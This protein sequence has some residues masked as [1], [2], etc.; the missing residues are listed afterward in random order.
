MRIFRNKWLAPVAFLLF[1]VPS[2]CH[3]NSPDD[4][5]IPRLTVNPTVSAPSSR[6]A[7]PSITPPVLPTSPSCD[8]L[9]IEQVREALG[10]GE[11]QKPFGNLF[12]STNG[13]AGVLLDIDMCSWQQYAGTDPGRVVQVEVH[14]AKSVADA[15][16]EYESAISQLIEHT[17]PNFRPLPVLNLGARAARLPEWLVVQKDRVMLAVSVSRT[18]NGAAPDPSILEELA[19][20][21]ATRLGW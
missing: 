14:T 6:A 4:S 17:A 7:N 11:V 21:V 12:P 9:T 1:L 13:F 20:D 19:R 5:E 2:G 3:V 18:T 8:L 15:N 10:G 16:Q